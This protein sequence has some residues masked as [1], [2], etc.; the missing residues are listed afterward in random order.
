[1]KFAHSLGFPHYDLMLARMTSSQLMEL[2]A[3]FDGEVLEQEHSEI[4][5]E[6]RNI[7]AF[8]E[9]AEAKQEEKNG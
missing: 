2:Y 6:S 5:E 4:E 8:F 1:M 7:E 3:F 9:I